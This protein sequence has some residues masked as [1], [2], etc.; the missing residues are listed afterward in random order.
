MERDMAD[1]GDTRFYELDKRVALL[2]QAQI[3]IQK[4]LH[5]ISANLNKLVW[6]LITAVVV[7]V[8]NLWVKTGGGV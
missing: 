8:I 7:G 4:E 2:E 1:A 6:V 3:N 5:S